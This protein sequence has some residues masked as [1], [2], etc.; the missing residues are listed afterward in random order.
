[1]KSLKELA[2]EHP[3]YCSGSNYYSNEDNLHY[4]TW[5]E[6]SEVFMDADI[7]WNLCFRWDIIEDTKFVDGIHDIKLG[8]YSM[9]V[10]IMKQRKGIFTPV[11]ISR[12]FEED[13]PS[14]L[15]YLDKHYNRLLEMW[16]PFK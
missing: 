15:E 14:I 1:M 5:K 3:Y 12:I 6:F 16:E 10:F 4:N 2:V 7:D 11:K 8:T 13:V 9:E